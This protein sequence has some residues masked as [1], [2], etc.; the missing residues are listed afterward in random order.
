MPPFKNLGNPASSSEKKTPL[1]GGKTPVFFDT[2][3]A[4]STIKASNLAA[5]QRDS[6]NPEIEA[7]QS[8]QTDLD[9]GKTGYHLE[10]NASSTAPAIPFGPIRW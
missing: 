9:V 7:P 3:Q 2:M 6:R 4:G 10:E 5:Q 8:K 1:A